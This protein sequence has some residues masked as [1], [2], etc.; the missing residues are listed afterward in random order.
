MKKWDAGNVL[1]VMVHAHSTTHGP[2]VM[3]V[4]YSVVLVA[5]SLLLYP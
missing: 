5:S 4:I 2:A 3:K 1:A